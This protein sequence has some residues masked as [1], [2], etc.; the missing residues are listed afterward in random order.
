MQA[1]DKVIREAQRNAAYESLHY[2][3]LQ[4]IEILKPKNGIVDNINLAKLLNYQLKCDN[5]A[6]S[7]E[8]IN[9]WIPS[10]SR[11]PEIK[12]KYIDN[13]TLQFK[14]DFFA[15]SF[16]PAEIDTLYKKLAKALPKYQH[17]YELQFFS[18]ANTDSWLYCATITD[19][20]EFKALTTYIDKKDE[21]RPNLQHVFIDAADNDMI[22]SDSHILATRPI[23][24]ERSAMIPL[25]AQKYI[26]D[27]K[28]ESTIYVDEAGDKMRVVNLFDEKIFAVDTSLKYPQYKAVIPAKTDKT[29]I[30]GDKKE[31]LK[32][33]KIAAKNANK[34][35]QLLKFRFEASQCTISAGDIDF[36][37]SS[38]MFI[39]CT[40]TISGEIGFNASRLETVLKSIDSNAIEFNLTDHNRAVMINDNSLIMPMII[41][42]ENFEYITQHAAPIAEPQTEA[43]E[44]TGQYLP[45]SY[46]APAEIVRNL[47]VTYT[48]HQETAEAEPVRY[49][50]V[51][52]VKPKKIR[53]PRAKKNKEPKEKPDIWMTIRHEARENVAPPQGRARKNRLLKYIYMFAMVCIMLIINADKV[54]GKNNLSKR[55]KIRS[56]VLQESKKAVHLYHNNSKKADILNQS[57]MFT[58]N[59]VQE[60][61]ENL[62]RNEV[63]ACVSS[64]AEFILSQDSQNAPFSYDDIEKSDVYQEYNENGIYFAGGDED[65]RDSFIEEL[66]KERDE[67]Q[68]SD[69]EAN[70]K[71]IEDLESAI[72]DIKNLDIEYM[73][74]LE[75]WI[76]SDYLIQKLASFGEPVIKSESIWCR[77]TSGQSITMDGV[78]QSIAKSI[79]NA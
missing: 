19:K 54:N 33:I 20:K 36:S 13:N 44:P 63:F 5:V 78:I 17:T 32:S 56:E 27:S 15:Y 66:E 1:T 67:L 48:A 40:S 41:G 22:A 3:C 72:Y 14:S 35:S 57:K 46:T 70:E 79:I 76:C 37:V 24:A 18:D 74:I 28:H 34:A 52:Y 29:V 64:M 59:K 50:P 31:L 2:A 25:D 12:D 16:D 11:H 6:I 68:D 26:A 43:I 60:M 73:D 61:A 42:A 8:N 38:S 7:Y 58:E 71:R 10:N 65:E 30:F 75:Y 39:N 77:Q 51:L 21:L 45:V 55:E 53:K 69:A 62:V 47:P 4:A 9:D 23:E 49:L